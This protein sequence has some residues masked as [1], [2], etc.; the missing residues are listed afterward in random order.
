MAY[1]RLQLSLLF[2]SDMMKFR[3]FK[4]E[5]E[6][7]IAENK[8][9]QEQIQ[10]LGSEKRDFQFQVCIMSFCIIVNTLS[11]VLLVA[12]DSFPPLVTP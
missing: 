5:I 2:N 1:E 7:L 10:T 3:Q 8:S 6:R 9:L 11:S 12:N 4:E